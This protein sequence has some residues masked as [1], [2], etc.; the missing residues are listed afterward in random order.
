MS[1][2]RKVFYIKRACREYLKANFSIRRKPTAFW[3][4]EENTEPQLFWI[5]EIP[6]FCLEARQSGALIIFE[7]KDSYYDN[8]QLFKLAKNQI[9]VMGISK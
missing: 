8:E 9:Q 5:M 2:K 4:R 3:I 1:D 6:L 7:N